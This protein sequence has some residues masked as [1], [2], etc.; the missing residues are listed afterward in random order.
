M[1]KSLIF[2][3]ALLFSAAAGAQAYKWADKN[4]KVQYGDVPPPGVTATPV[5]SVST[6]PAPPAAKQDD[7][8]GAAKKGPMTPAEQEADYR[9]RQQEA[10]KDR[11]KQAQAQQEAD[12]KRENCARAHEMLRSLSSG[13]VSR[14]DA[15]GERY[16]LDDAQLA[17]ETA[18]AQQAVQQWCN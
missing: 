4:G 16:Y 14:T 7:A 2:A 17:Q 15:K 5:R 8:K 11:Q 18:K 1:K 10:E 13:R 9:K 6:P 12:G 3:A